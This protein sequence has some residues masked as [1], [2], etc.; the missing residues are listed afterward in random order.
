MKEKTS[1]K[2]ARCNQCG[3]PAVIMHAEKIPLCVDCYKKV[4]QANFL[5]QQARHNQMSWLASQMNLT[6]QYLYQGMGGILPLKQME[7]PQPPSAGINYSYSNIQVSD[8]AVGAISFGD[9]YTLDTSIEVM[10]THGETELA[11]AIKELSEAIING[12]DIQAESQ[13]EILKLITYLSS[14]ASQSKDKRNNT[15]MKTVLDKLSTIIPVATIAWSIWERIEP[16]LKSQL[17][18]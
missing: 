11:T 6:Q 18:S 10:K 14:E 17:G 16:L 9:L 4:A 8:S 12:T 5:E 15:V 7:I 13:N 3:K 1:K 2:V